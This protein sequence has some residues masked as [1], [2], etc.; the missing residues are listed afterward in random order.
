MKFWPQWHPVAYISKKLFNIVK[1]GIL[2]VILEGKRKVTGSHILESFTET[3]YKEK[4]L[5]QC[6]WVL[7][8]LF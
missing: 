6:F 1:V 3:C 7:F 2:E 4:F 5:H 8:I